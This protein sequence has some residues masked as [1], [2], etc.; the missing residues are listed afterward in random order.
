MPSL[1]S[2]KGGALRPIMPG[3]I[4]RTFSLWQLVPTCYSAKWLHER[5]LSMNSGAQKP[6]NS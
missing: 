1:D 6:L 4:I 2:S 5:R 3:K